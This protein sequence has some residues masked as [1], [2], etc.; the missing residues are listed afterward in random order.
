MRAFFIVVSH[1]LM[2]ELS[3]LRERVE[4]VGVEHLSAEGAVKAFD[5]GVLGRFTRLD[6]VEADSVI[7]T[8]CCQFGGD[9]FGAVI[10]P[11]LDR[12]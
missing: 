8:P 9:K 2:D 12:Q 11:N 1:P 6:M 4:D 5:I 3:D 7:L 10:D